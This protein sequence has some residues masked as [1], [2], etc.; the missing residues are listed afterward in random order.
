MH[1]D[2]S[3]HGRYYATSTCATWAWNTCFLLFFLLFFFFPFH[4]SEWKALSSGK[5]VTSFSAKKKITAVR[6]RESSLFVECFID[7]HDRSAH[8]SWLGRPSGNTYFI[9]TVR[10]R[11]LRIRSS[12]WSVH[13]H[14]HRS[15]V[16]VSAYV[17]RSLPFISTDTGT[18]AAFIRNGTIDPEYRRSDYFLPNL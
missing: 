12:P 14:R 2:V 6:E 1:N 4:G 18:P 3:R 16:C 15:Y 9:G 11:R 13:W 7:F 8:N 10:K 17:L 5:C